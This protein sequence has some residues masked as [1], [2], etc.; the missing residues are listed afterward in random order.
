MTFLL[1]DDCVA[2][3]ITTTGEGNSYVVN[4][5]VCYD[6]LWTVRYRLW[7]GITGDNHYSD[8]SFCA[9][10]DQPCHNNNKNR[11]DRSRVDRGDIPQQHNQEKQ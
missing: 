6:A 4:E 8:T 1:L 2:M 5:G 11:R 10:E 7:N 9:A 3:T